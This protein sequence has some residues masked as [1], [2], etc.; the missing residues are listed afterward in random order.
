MRLKCIA[1]LALALAPL[2]PALAQEP[3]T[4]DQDKAGRPI[5]DDTV[6]VDDIALTP[7][8]DLNLT[9][10]EIDAL[11]VQAREAPYDM[12]GIHRCSDIISAVQQLDALLGED[13]DSAEARSRGVSPGKIAQWAIGRFI[14]FRG[15]V[16][17]V[18]G[19]RAHERKVRDAIVGGMM[20]RGF[21]KGV[22]QQKG[23]K[24]PGR[25]ARAE[26]VLD[27]RE[28]EAARE[29]A[30]D[31]RERIDKRARKAQRTSKNDNDRSRFIAQPVVQATP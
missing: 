6:R 29:R 23:C 22:G 28:N 5:T 9:R 14:P 8:S 15:L 31:H 3:E 20:R 24:Y 18:S 17:E 10:D 12:T 7:L 11:L 16:R 21:L 13:L 4:A 19:A 1:P 26:E 2:T 27:R 25:P 30:E